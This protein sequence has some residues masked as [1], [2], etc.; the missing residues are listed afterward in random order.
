[1]QYLLDCKPAHLSYRADEDSNV[2]KLKAS[3]QR[4]SPASA[5]T[6]GPPLSLTL[7]H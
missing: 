5:E 1:L 2:R 3:G 6:I 4:G 7:K